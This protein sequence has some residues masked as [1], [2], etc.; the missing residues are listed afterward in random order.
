[1]DIAG[2]AYSVVGATS[3]SAWARFGEDFAGFSGTS[4]SSI[5]AIE[6]PNF[7]RA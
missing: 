4:S 2:L 6:R 5:Q 3:L 7:K 1:M